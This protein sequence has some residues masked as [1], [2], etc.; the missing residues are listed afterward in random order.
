MKHS[1]VTKVQTV[2]YR[3]TARAEAHRAVVEEP[4]ARNEFMRP[5]DAD[6]VKVVI[7]GGSRPLFV[8]PRQLSLP[9]VG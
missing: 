7:E 6:R 2:I 5:E 9:K 4:R 1:E 3:A 8:R